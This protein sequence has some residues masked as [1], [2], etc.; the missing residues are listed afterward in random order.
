MSV[1]RT[2]EPIVAWRWWRM[3]NVE[4]R[5]Y[6]DRDTGERVELEGVEPHLLS[7][8]EIERQLGKKKAGEVGIGKTLGPR[9]D[10]D[11]WAEDI[12]DAGGALVDVPDNVERATIREWMLRSISA[13]AVWPGPVLEAHEV[14]ELDDHDAHVGIHC[15]P[16]ADFAD[17]VR[18]RKWMS[19]GRMPAVGLIELSGRV[20]IHED[21]RGCDVLYRAQRATILRVAVPDV[22]APPYGLRHRADD[23]PH[24]E[25]Q[26]E[27]LEALYHCDVDVYRV[28][29]K[30]GALPWPE[31][32]P[33]GPWRPEMPQPDPNPMR[34]IQRVD[35]PDP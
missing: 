21:E 33:T 31:I 19:W 30:R 9:V 25:E 2:S 18:Y 14:P 7:L 22:L 5:I 12:E 6:R 29:E 17:G 27:Q 3:H 8:S 15:L 10:P 23:N 28:G 1:E 26:Q 34:H 32:Q 35:W 4:R 20:V 11:A 24:I 16:L 13:D